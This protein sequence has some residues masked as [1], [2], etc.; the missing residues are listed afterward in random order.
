LNSKYFILW[1]LGTWVAQRFVS[2]F[3]MKKI[4]TIAVAT[5][6]VLGG[7]SAGVYFLMP[8]W[9]PDSIRPKGPAHGKEAKKNEEGDRQT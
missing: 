6:V 4:I 1:N 5:I 3:A 7:A 2:K 8:D 9:L